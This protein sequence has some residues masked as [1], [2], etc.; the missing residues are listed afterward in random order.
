MPSC[1]TCI[2]WMQLQALKWVTLVASCLVMLTAGSMFTFSVFA[3]GLRKRFGYSSSDVNLISGFGNTALYVSFI[4]IG[5]MFDKLGA[6]VTLSFGTLAYGAGYLMMWLAYEGKLGI[7]V[8]PLMMSIFY[9]AAG[10][11]STA[12]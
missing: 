3:N 5:P 1:A 12:S 9:F 4:F 6:R 7:E 10:C 8:S 11:G 2:P